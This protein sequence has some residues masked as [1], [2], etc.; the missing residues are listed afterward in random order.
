MGTV[1]GQSSYLIKIIPKKKKSWLFRSFSGK[2]EE[3]D[4]KMIS[5]VSKNEES[6]SIFPL[7]W[8]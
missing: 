5:R 7:S 1:I 6:L 2:L 4:E 3:A 8:P